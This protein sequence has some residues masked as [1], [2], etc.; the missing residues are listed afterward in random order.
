[1]LAVRNT[2]RGAVDLG[3]D[4]LAALERHQ[5]T[6]LGRGVAIELSE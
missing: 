6:H 1:M 5:P 4:S 3:R 2:H